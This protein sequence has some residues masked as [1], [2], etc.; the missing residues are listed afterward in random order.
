M[1]KDDFKADLILCGDLHLT[2]AQPVCRTDDYVQSMWRKVGF[3]ADLQKKHNAPV[4]FPGDVCDKPRLPQTTERRA[5]LELPHF[6]AVP[7]QH[8]LPSHSIDNLPESSL[9]VIHAG[10][11]SDSH[12]LSP[13]HRRLV[14]CTPVA[15]GLCLDG[16]WWGRGNDVCELPRDTV[17]VAVMHRMVWT[18]RVPYPGCKADSAQKLMAS[19]PSYDLIVTGDN[20][21]SF[22][23]E[24]KGRLLVNCGSV[25]RKEADQANH[26]PCV[27][28]Y[29]AKNNRVKK[30]HLPIRKGAVSRQHIEKGQQTDRSRE[31][32]IKNLVSL[33]RP[34]L[35]FRQNL[36]KACVDLEPEVKQTVYRS[37]AQ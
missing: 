11:K 32:L 36:D 20:H 14:L 19:L 22:V 9:A 29:D 7:G 13:D 27:Y 4:I 2:N 24:H 35:N 10:R 34:S 3:I 25:M 37:L 21:E 28:L 15:P 5:I 16:F 26:R 17:N 23:V 12:L 1:D 18:I 8:D 6:I 31:L 33:N 30:I